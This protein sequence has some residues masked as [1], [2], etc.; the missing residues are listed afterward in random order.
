VGSCSWTQ[1]SGVSKLLHSLPANAPTMR[2]H[3]AKLVL[4]RCPRYAQCSRHNPLRSACGLATLYGHSD[5]L[6]TYCYTLH[7]RSSSS[8]ATSQRTSG[9]V[10]CARCYLSCGSCTVP[11]CHHPNCSLLVGTRMLRVLLKKYLY[12]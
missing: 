10:R 2:M 7:G 6:L 12:F 9:S 3:A 5:S 1:L 4:H 8:T 11:N